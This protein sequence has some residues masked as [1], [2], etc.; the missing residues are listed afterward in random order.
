MKHFLVVLTLLLCLVFVG[1]V[2]QDGAESIVFIEDVERFSRI[3]MDELKDIM[4]EA[5][6]EE[7]WTNKT[8]K[9]DFLV[10][11]L[12]YDKDGN[13]YEFIIADNSV[14]RLSIYS[15][16]YWNG[17]GEPFKYRGAKKDICKSFNVTLSDNAKLITDTNFAYR[18]S[19]VNNKVADFNIQD[20]DGKTYGF[21][22]I[23]Y[24][25]NYFD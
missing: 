6:S 23:T 15:E 19:P 1:C 10:T 20:I 8:S 16:K 12:A 18:I 25:L 14:V 3:S 17:T 22:K 21:V 24:N 11:T 13:H 9:G 7:I 4:G 2:T 5:V